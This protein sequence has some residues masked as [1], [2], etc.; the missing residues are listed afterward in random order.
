MMKKILGVILCVTSQFLSAASIE[1]GHP[2]EMRGIYR[3][4][5]YENCCVGGVSK[6][7]KYAY[8]Q[9]E[10]PMVIESIYAPQP[11]TFKFNKVQLALSDSQKSSIPENALITVKCE[12]VMEGNT[13]HYALNVYCSN[14]KIGFVGHK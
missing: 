12:E 2:Y 6:N 4:G 8:L 10:K 11:T 13:G 1:F 14:P 7:T 5:T 3:T 9:L